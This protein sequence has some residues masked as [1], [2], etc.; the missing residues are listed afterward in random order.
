MSNINL[1][2]K[3]SDGHIRPPLE[4]SLFYYV[5]RQPKNG[6]IKNICFYRSTRFAPKYETSTA[7]DN[8]FRNTL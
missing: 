4:Q 3:Q 6:L 2:Y 5:K 7:N 1:L 8:K